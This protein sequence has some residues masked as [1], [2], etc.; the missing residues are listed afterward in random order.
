MPKTSSLEV[1]W[2]AATNLLPFCYNLKQLMILT[3]EGEV[4][5]ESFGGGKGLQKVE[6]G[7]SCKDLMCSVMEAGGASGKASASQCRRRKKRGCSSLGWE[8]PLL[9]WEEEMA[10]HS[11]IL[12]PEN[13]IDRG[14]WW[15][16]VHGVT[17]SQTR[18]K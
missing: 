11:S 4:T 13:P 1:G 15:A 17:K 14:A 7:G 12:C 9:G 3:I 8:D 16:T 5:L 2:Q 18:L 10:T 6:G